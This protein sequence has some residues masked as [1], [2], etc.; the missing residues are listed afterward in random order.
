MEKLGLGTIGTSWITGSFIDAA[1]ATERYDLNCVYSRNEEKGKE[2]SSKYGD[3]PVETDLDMFMNNEALDVI[4]IASPN[5]LHYE[6]ALMALRAK[7]H[8]MVEKPASTKVEEW[9]EMLRVAE[10]NDVFVL[11]AAKHMY[12][13]NLERIATEIDKLDGVVGATFPYVRYSSRY[14]NVLAG[15][16]PNIFSLKFAGGALMDLGIYPIYTAVALFG[17]PEEAIYYPRKIRTGVDGIGTVILRYKE[18]D[19]TILVGKIATSSYEVEIYG[20][21]ETLVIDHVSH[22]GKACK[23]DHQTLEEQEVSL[24]EQHKNSMFY[25]A[26]ALAQ[27]IET[28]DEPETLERYEELSDLARIVSGLLNHLLTQADIIFDVKR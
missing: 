20:A 18:F 24:V 22:L 19:V 16:E 6:Q 3:I 25:E 27:M 4:Y 13:P 12:I 8:V 23:I 26:E 21:K 11:E 2:F 15:E 1:L 28:K 17:E 7:K 14:D 5:S 10:E 9:D